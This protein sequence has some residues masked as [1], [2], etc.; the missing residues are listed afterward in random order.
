[1][2]IIGVDPHKGSHTAAALDGDEHTIA[3]LRVR[4]DASQHQHLLAW[5]APFAPRAW[6]VEGA[7][8]TGARLAQ[9][10]VAA[11]EVV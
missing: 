1:M 9:Q 11:G 8:G 7:T 3:E 6:A 10:L 4:A 2:F 5:A